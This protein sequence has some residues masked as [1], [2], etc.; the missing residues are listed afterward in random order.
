[1]LHALAG[2]IRVVGETGADG[3]EAAPRAAAAPP[4]AAALVTRLD[5]AGGQFVLQGGAPVVGCQGHAHRSDSTSPSPAP[6]GPPP[7][8]VVRDGRPSSKPGGSP[9]P[10]APGLPRGPRCRRRVAAGVPRWPWGRTSLAGSSSGPAGRP[11]T[12]L[13]GLRGWGRV[14]RSSGRSGTTPGHA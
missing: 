11:R 6:R 10:L 5:Q 7:I 14:P 3:A 9:S 12:R 13:A 2:R 1:M 8:I 4:R